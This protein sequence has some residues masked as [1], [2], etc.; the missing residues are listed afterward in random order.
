MGASCSKV[1]DRDVLPPQVRA[2]AVVRCEGR[3]RPC[4]MGSVLGGRRTPYILTY[5]TTTHP[6]NT[7]TTAPQ[8]Q[9]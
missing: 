7:A 6:A 9:G 5:S 3:R 1:A 4:V 8:P 2:D